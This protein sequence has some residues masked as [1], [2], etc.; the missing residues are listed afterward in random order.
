MNNLVMHY[1]EN[2]EL[3]VSNN[4]TNNEK[5]G[6]CQELLSNKQ[7]YKLSPCNH[8]FH[9]ECIVQWFRLDNNSCPY[10]RDDGYIPYESIYNSSKNWK[11]TFLRNYSRRK[12]A[13]KIL[14][15]FVKD[16]KNNEE[17]LKQLNINI[18]EIYNKKGLAKELFKESRMLKLKKW[19]VV[20]KI[21]K[22]KRILKNLPIIPLYIK[23]VVK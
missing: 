2:N 20:R 9:T 21:N 19:K 16:L 7:S 6:I 22:N 11:I 12:N 10:C 1:D 5:C 13:P 8:E 4:Y 3:Q 15:K 23:K 14:K 17:K 18:K